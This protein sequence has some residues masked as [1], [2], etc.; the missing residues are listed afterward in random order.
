MLE[1]FFRGIKVQCAR[2]DRLSTLP[3][4]SEDD[5]EG[6][7]K[8]LLVPSDGDGAVGVWL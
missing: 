3:P 7:V 5:L 8:V 4:I 6:M 2:L 1:V